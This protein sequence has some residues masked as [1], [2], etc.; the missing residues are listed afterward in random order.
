MKNNL[1]IKLLAIA[2]G[3]KLKKSDALICLEGDGWSRADFAA[4]LFRKNWAEKI[5]ISGGLFNL[6]F[7]VPA[8][9]LADYLIKKGISKER[10]ILEKKSKNTR[11]QAVEVIKIAKERKWQRVI[12]VASYFHQPR[13]YL[14]FL[15]AMEESGF[16]I[17]IFN[18]PVKEVSWFEKT[19]LGSSRLELLEKEFKK[20]EDYTKK[21]HLA[22]IKKLLE[23]QKWKEKQN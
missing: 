4:K 15:K 5:V 14:T 18:A 3:E 19:S 2:N 10:I 13:A 8:E 17:E 22:P 1:A 12:L 16:K 11:E 20:I 23:Y 7:S 6:P 21:G 9:D